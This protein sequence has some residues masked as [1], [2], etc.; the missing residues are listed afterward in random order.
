MDLWGT[1]LD[2]LW[3]IN[4]LNWFITSWDFFFMPHKDWKP[5]LINDAEDDLHLMPMTGSD[6]L[7]LDIS[8]AS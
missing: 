6:D 4:P 2:F 7:V 1:F 8:S 3:L 5:F